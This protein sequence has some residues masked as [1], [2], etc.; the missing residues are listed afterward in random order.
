MAWMVELVEWNEK[1]H[2]NKAPGPSR[3]LFYFTIL[4]YLSAQ[5]TGKVT[6]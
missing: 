4:F 1:E 2:D 6:S 5:S 3:R